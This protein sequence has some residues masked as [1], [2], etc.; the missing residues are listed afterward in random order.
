MSHYWL[1]NTLDCNG[2]AEPVANNGYLIHLTA[3][4][5]AKTTILRE[6]RSQMQ[7]LH[8]GGFF[9]GIFTAT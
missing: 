7:K 6:N 3:A 5:Y 9:V 1:K 4:N 8:I 2:I